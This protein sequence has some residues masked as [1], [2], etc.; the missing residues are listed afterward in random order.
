MEILSEIIFFVLATCSIYAARSS[1]YVACCSVYAARSS[2]YAAC[3]SVYAARCAAG[4]LFYMDVVQFKCDFAVFL[5]EAG[6]A[7][8]STRFDC[9]EFCVGVT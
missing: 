6:N 4:S 9:S 8:C 3:C 2:V 5:Y 1:I 7:N